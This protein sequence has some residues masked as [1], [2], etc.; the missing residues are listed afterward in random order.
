M[1]KIYTRK[2]DDGTTGLLYGG[3]RVSKNAPVIEANGVVDEAQAVIGLAR[4]EAAPGGE[5]DTLLIGVE[6]DLW[7]L[8]AEVATAPVNRRRLTPGT[9]LVTPQMVSFLEERIDELN[10]RFEMPSE[11]VVPGQNRIA[12]LLDVARTVVRRGERLVVG[13]MADVD[14]Q[15]GPYLNR[16]S[17]LLWTMARW[18]EG[19]HL[20]TRARGDAKAGAKKGARNKMNNA[21]HENEERPAP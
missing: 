19:E 12:A 21:A 15:V 7:V 20:L 13:A 5:L 14:S 16:L 18:Q 6:R 9:S 3:P 8:M 2:G 11:F 1:A 10:E 4:A 17:D